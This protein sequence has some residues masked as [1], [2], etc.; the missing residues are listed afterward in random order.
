M[1]GI[2]DT[3]SRQRYERERAAR[4]KAEAVLEEKSRELFELQRTRDRFFVNINHE[5]RT[6]LNGILGP[7]QMMQAEDMPLQVRQFGRIIEACGHE[8][9]QL[10]QSAIDAGRIDVSVKRELSESGPSQPCVLVVDD[11]HVN[12]LV[13]KA[14]I[15]AAGMRARQATNGSEALQYMRDAE[16]DA[17]IM[18]I[19]MPVMRGD[20]AIRAIRSSGKRWNQVPII[21]VTAD[22]S[23]DGIEHYKALGATDYLT[24]PLVVGQLQTKLCQLISDAA[25]EKVLHAQAR[26]GG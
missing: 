25:P 21:V 2:D 7:A 4:L 5:F 15:E 20:D 14:A 3:V 22:A 16:A 19:Q 6:P 11:N 24:K 10:L 1:T 18:D 9:M 26:R 23:P 13:A 8:L 12:R 17:I